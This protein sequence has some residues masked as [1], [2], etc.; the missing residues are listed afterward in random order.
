MALPP[1]VCFSDRPFHGLKVCLIDQL[2][3][4]REEIIVQLES[5]EGVAGA[6]ET[7]QV[8]GAPA[9]GVTAALGLALG[10]EKFVEKKGATI[11]TGELDEYWKALVERM[12]RTR[13]TAVNLFWA[14]SKMDEEYNAQSPRIKGEFHSLVEVMFI[15]AQALL[16][17]D[18]SLCHAIGKNGAGL[19][20][21]KA[22]VLT[23]CN[24]GALA[25]AGYGTALGIIRAAVEA[26][27]NVKVFCDET[28]PYL[29]GSR[30]TAW[31]LQRDGIDAT[32]ITDNMAAHI[33]KTEK[34]D[35]VI[36]GADRIARNGDTAN[37]IGTYG[38]SILC[39][40]HGIP[41][42]VAAPSTTFDLKIVSGAQIPIEER[43]K[44]EVSHIGTTVLVPEGVSVRHPAFDVT[45]AALIT[46][47]ITERGIIQPV[48]EERVCDLMEK[49]S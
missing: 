10:L 26:G 27:K 34:I 33:M 1:T 49:T 17:E 6:I 39:K 31:E 16:D 13:P 35:A 44:S 22:T 25:T 21:Q 9:I 12:N 2:R 40:H 14:T 41:L 30:L 48:C 36:V 47:I 32:V 19:L 23:H 18:I 11:K 7:M 8:R 46:S 42:Y 38:L 15:K 5:A 29:Q 43:S 45:P 37:K 28:R 24:A 3:L 20:P 4:P